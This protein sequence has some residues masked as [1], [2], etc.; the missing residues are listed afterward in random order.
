L[1]DQAELAWTQWHNY[2][3]PR[4]PRNAGAIIIISIKIVHK[5]HTHKKMKHEK[6]K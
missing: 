3:W 6:V 1:D 5:V 2:Y 4:R